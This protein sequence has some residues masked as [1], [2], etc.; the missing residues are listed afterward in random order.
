MI[1]SELLAECRQTWLLHSLIVM[2]SLPIVLLLLGIIFLQQW[3][4]A[5]MLSSLCFAGALLLWLNGM[6]TRILLY[7]NKLIKHSLFG[8]TT[9]RLNAKTE[10]YYHHF[11]PIRGLKVLDC[12]FITL[13]QSKQSVTFYA[14]KNDL[15]I[16]QQLLIELEHTYQEPVIKSLIVR[17]QSIRFGEIRLSPT[18]LIYKKQKFTFS[19]MKECSLQQSGHFRIQLQGKTPLYMDIPIKKIPN[20]A[21]LLSLI[22]HY[23]EKRAS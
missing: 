19:E 5:L 2:I 15:A 14:N 8:T 12:F 21:T 22:D 7:P 9:L 18:A 23:V 17:G 1:Q 4:Y 10:F 20:T 11:Q 13:K 3:A 6:K 16:V